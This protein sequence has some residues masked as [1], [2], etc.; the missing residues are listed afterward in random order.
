MPDPEPE[1]FAGRY[2]IR[3]PLGRGATKTVYLAHDLRLARDVALSL[4]TAATAADRQRV[5]AE[6]RL[7]A[8]LGDH[9]HVI[10]VHDA[11]EEDGV[12][13]IV[14]RLMEGRTLAEATRPAP[15]AGWRR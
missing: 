4:V 14:A 10:T 12:P 15:A 2:V 5:V 7:L 9:P 8:Q 13:Y 11:G 3:R 1:T 6:A